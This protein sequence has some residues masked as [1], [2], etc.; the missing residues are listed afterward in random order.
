MR[1]ER[2][3]TRLELSL[4][5]LE[6]SLRRLESSLQRLELSLHRLEFS[7]TRLEF[8][9]LAME[10]SCSR[11]DVTWS[12]PECAS[13][14][15]ERLLFRFCRRRSHLLSS[16]RAENVVMTSFSTRPSRLAP[17]SSSPSSALPFEQS[18]LLPNAPLATD[19]VGV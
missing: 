17:L 18:S 2:S 4:H 6:S 7:W 5:R 14:C 10:S 16:E 19:T 1:R 3:T 13:Q 11:G 12:R 15:V 9:W 8:G